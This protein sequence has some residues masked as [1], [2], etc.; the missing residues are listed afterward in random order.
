MNIVSP[1][2]V[3][4]QLNYGEASLGLLDLSIRGDREVFRLSEVDDMLDEVAPS[5]KS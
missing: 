5:I 4:C 3:G 2:S 1:C